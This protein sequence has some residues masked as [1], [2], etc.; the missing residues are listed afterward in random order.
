MSARRK[1]RAP[2]V[3]WVWMG[4]SD[5]RNAL[6]WPWDQTHGGKY[7]AGND[8]GWVFWHGVWTHHTDLAS[9]QAYWKRNGWKVKP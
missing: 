5:L 9:T 4:V 8:N 3:A 1:R 7:S 6:C 2:A